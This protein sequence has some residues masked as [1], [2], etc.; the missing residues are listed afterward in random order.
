MGQVRGVDFR[1]TWKPIGGR[2]T[3]EK[4]AKKQY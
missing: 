3:K 4:K 1:G 2:E